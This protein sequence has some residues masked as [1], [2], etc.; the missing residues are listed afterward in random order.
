MTENKEN[1]RKNIAIQTQSFN[2]NPLRIS[3]D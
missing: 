1:I 2:Y 3:F